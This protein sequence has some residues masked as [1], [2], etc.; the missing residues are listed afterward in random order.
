MQNMLRPIVEAAGYIVIGDG[1]ELL[2]D[3]VIQ[4]DGD[5]AARR[6]ATRKC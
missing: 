3:L 1:D 4:S 2:P 5:A 6:P